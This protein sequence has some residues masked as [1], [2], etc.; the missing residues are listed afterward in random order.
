MRSER[1]NTLVEIIFFLRSIKE[2]A[3]EKPLI[4]RI[5]T[6]IFAVATINVLTNAPDIKAIRT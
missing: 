6:D 2:N 1:K 5:I 3:K 4:A